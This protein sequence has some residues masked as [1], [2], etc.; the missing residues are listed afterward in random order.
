MDEKESEGEIPL[1]ASE[2]NGL[3]IP[4]VKAIRGFPRNVVRVILDKRRI[5]PSSFNLKTMWISELHPLSVTDWPYSLN[6]NF[7]GHSEWL[8]YLQPGEG[9]FFAG[10]VAALL[11]VR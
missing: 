1:K 7:Y 9:C 10:K 11:T 8:F 3:D 4:C 2:Q 6:I 5:T